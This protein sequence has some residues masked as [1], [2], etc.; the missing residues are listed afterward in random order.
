M[1]TPGAPAQERATLEE[2]VD[3]TARPA[4]AVHAAPDGAGLPVSRV[5]PLPASPCAPPGLVSPLAAC[6]LESPTSV[7]E[8]SFGLEQAA[9]LRSSVAIVECTEVWEGGMARHLSFD[10]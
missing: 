6:M 4:V 5:V 8:P 9:T 7:V 3:V 10:V 1:A 2:D